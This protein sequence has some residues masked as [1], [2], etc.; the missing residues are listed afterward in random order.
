[1]LETRPRWND[2]KAP[3]TELAIARFDINDE[4]GTWV[5]KCADR[6]G[7][8]HDYDR[9]AP[10]KR[11]EDLLRELDEDPTRIFWG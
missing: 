8:W 5:L 3:W 2:A 4:N 6:N 7:R 1:M 9:V 10:T 11:F